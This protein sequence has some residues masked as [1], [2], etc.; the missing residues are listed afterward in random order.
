MSKVDAL[1]ESV[2][3][4]VDEIVDT[5]VLDRDGTSTEAAA[6]AKRREVSDRGHGC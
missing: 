3:A 2:R 5:H 6:Y 4:L 1:S